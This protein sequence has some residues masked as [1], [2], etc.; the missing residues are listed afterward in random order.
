MEASNG[1]KCD[2]KTNCSIPTRGDEIFLTQHATPPEFGRK[3]GTECPNT[4][5]S[6]STLLCAGYSVKLIKKIK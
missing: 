3:W 2:S 6:L 5:F 4:R 1:T